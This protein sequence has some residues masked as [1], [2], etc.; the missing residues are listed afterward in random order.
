MIDALALSRST[1]WMKHY[2][3]DYSSELNCKAYRFGIIL[4]I[5]ADLNSNVKMTI[6]IMFFLCTGKEGWESGEEIREEIRKTDSVEIRARVLAVA[7]EEKDAVTTGAAED[8]GE[9]RKIVDVATEKKE[10]KDFDNEKKG[11]EVSAE[12]K[13]K[14]LSKEKEREEDSSK[15]KEREEVSSKEKEREKVSSEEKEKEEVSSEEK[16]REEVSS[17]EEE[18]VTFSSEEKEKA[19]ISSEEGRE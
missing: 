11:I 10:A 18:R 16:E 12:E 6:L 5:F 15:E 14:V 1:L 19:D 3:Y 8:L 13:K 2:R 7:E 4:R 9:G 17:E